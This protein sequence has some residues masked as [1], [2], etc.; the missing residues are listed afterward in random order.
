MFNRNY[1][2]EYWVD[3]AVDYT[4]DTVIKYGVL[5]VVPFLMSVEYYFIGELRTLNYSTVAI[6][7]LLSEQA[8]ANSSGLSIASLGILGNIAVWYPTSPQQLSYVINV[9]DH[10]PKG[11][12]P[13][14][15]ASMM[16]SGNFYLADTSVVA[17]LHRSQ[18]IRHLSPTRFVA[19]TE[20]ITAEIINEQVLDTKTLIT[21]VVR[22]VLVK[23]LLNIDLS[24]DQQKELDYFFRVFSERLTHP[25]P[26]LLSY[27]FNFKN[28]QHRY[29]LFVQG[30][31]DQQL[32][33]ITEQQNNPEFEQKSFI[34]TALLDLI[35]KAN[36]NKN[37]VALLKQ[38]SQAKIK[39]YFNDPNLKALPLTL[40]AADNLIGA[41]IKGVQLAMA[42]D[43]IIELYNEMIEHNLFNNAKIDSRVLKTLPKLNGLFQKA[44]HE[45]QGSST[46]YRYAERGLQHAGLTIP[47]HTTVII[48]SKLKFFDAENSDPLF[49]APFSLGRRRCPGIS[50]SENIFKTVVV[51]MV[52][53]TIQKELQHS[54]RLKVA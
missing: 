53:H 34:L 42:D 35:A 23:A 14:G 44:V 17:M 27:D 5:T 28:C 13:Y 50:V 49:S 11:R 4:V 38:M 30:I 51:S 18:V 39:E 19:L 7:N 32:T 22:K 25:W 24:E 31:L 54:R 26:E 15:V 16:A 21:T 41:L 33:M 29:R 43:N 12:R 45:F 47:P 48:K 40:I 8:K 52:N 37:A 36:P 10:E 2:L 46:V 1:H 20:Q 9:L 6:E 3:K